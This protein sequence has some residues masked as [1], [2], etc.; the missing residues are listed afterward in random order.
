MLNQTVLESSVGPQ[1]TNFGV[2]ANLSSLLPYKGKGSF[3]FYQL[4]CAINA[5]PAAEGAK[6]W[7]FVSL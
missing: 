5:A 6:E 3:C 4:L 7:R 1:Q 2:F